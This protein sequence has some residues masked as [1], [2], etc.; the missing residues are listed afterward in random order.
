MA[1]DMD[2]EVIMNSEVEVRENDRELELIDISGLLDDAWKGIKKFWWLFFL[3][4]SLMASLLY[5]YARRSYQPVYTAYATYIVT[6]Q[7]MYSGNRAYNQK[8]AEQIGSVFP[9]IL[10]S[11]VL[12]QMVQE[13]LGVDAFPGSVSAAVVEGTNLITVS[14]K[15]NSAQMAYDL[16]CAVVE[17]Y[18]SVAQYVMG[19]CS[20]DIM[21]ESGIPI[22]PD[23]LPALKRWAA[24]GALFGCGIAVLLI[25]I[26]ALTRDT[27]KKEDDLKKILNIKCLGVLPK[28]KFKKRRSVK[29]PLVLINNPMIPPAFLEANRG[30]RTRLEHMLQGLNGNTFLITSAIEGEGKT[31]TACNMALALTMRG[32][33]VL[34]IDGDMRKP[35]LA[36]VLGMEPTKYGLYEILTRKVTFEEAAEPYKDGKLK[37]IAGGRT[38]LNTQRLLNGRGVKECMRG[39]RYCADFVIIDTPPCAL[40]SDAAVIAQY[41][42]GAVYVVRQDYA[43]RDKILEGVEVLAETGVKLIGC[44]LN[45]AEAGITG[46][47]YG[48]GYGGYGYK[49]YGRYG[50]YGRKTEKKEKQ[51]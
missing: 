50:S 40:M 15:A 41:V 36:K 2:M 47:G 8:T 5:F 46:Y 39:L 17:N 45:Q 16:L 43:K 13:E 42:K 29:N 32:H 37:V 9:Y 1:M 23:E 4:A 33:S 28:A 44:V 38:V 24:K 21:D 18:P 49:K 11:N 20:M 26:Y 19:E 3:F 6:A 48:Y 35:S 51:I 31:T 34:L 14:A 27:V 10:S 22:L 12:T 30:I 25:L 7:N